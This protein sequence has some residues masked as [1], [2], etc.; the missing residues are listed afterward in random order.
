ML[1]LIIQVKNEVRFGGS[2]ELP[3]SPPLISSLA[4]SS[5]GGIRLAAPKPHAV[6]S[7]IEQV[8]KIC[9]YRARKMSCGSS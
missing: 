7:P 1:I 9:L 5:S 4:Q 2:A 8:R 3:R 6:L